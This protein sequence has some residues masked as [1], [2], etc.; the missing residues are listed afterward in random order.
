MLKLDH[1]SR[2]NSLLIYYAPFNVPA[3]W[4]WAQVYAESD[5]TP[6]A[7]SPAGALGLSQFMPPTWEE[8]GNGGDAT[9]PEHA[10]QTQAAYMSWLVSQ[11]DND[12]EKATCAYNW[13]IGHIKRAGPTWRSKLPSETRNYLKRITDLYNSHLFPEEPH[14]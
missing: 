3:K 4:L 13:G 8:W 6:T 11:C 5:F 9:N 7:K 12:L 2:Y 1:R 10:I 14:D